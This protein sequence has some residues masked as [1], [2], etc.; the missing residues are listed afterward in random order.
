MQIPVPYFEITSHQIDQ[1]L[2][3]KKKKKT[4]TFRNFTVVKNIMKA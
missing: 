2:L 3:V 4:R 1:Q